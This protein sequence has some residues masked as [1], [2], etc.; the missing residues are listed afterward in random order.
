MKI[1]TIVGIRK[2]GKTTTVTRLVQELKRR[3]YQVGTVKTVFCP[4]FSMDQEG[5]N[6]DRHKKAGADV[7]GVKGKN[8]MN[9]IYPRGMDDNQFFP[10]LDADILLVE[11]DYEAGVPRIVCAHRRQDAL[12]RI[13]EYT[14]A[15]CGK[16]GGKGETFGSLPVIDILKEDKKAAD[17]VEKLP[18]VVFPIPL[19]ET[20][21][22]VSSF[23]QCG[24]RRGEKKCS[25]SLPVRP[26]SGSRKHI[27]LT[28]KKQVGKSTILE[29]A[30]KEL[31]L[32]FCGYRTLPYEIG[33]VRKG[34]Y[35]HGL[36][37]MDAFQNDCP[38]S[39]RAGERYS[40]P[41]TETFETLGTAI[42][43]QA[44]K[45]EKIMLAD[46]VGKLERDAFRFQQMFFRCLNEKKQVLGVLQDTDTPFV[47]AI[48]ER[49]DVEIWTVTEENR[50]C[51]YGSLIK[52][53]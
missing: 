4:T 18:D 16:I 13:N 49:P 29:K 11:G 28:G 8:E 36:E 3:G 2:S 7:V 37:E 40:Y 45:S 39:V 12:E 43:E 48:K 1:C 32:A 17:I 10:L 27:F 9:I 35:L 46:E 15:V 34:F 20:P 6:T 44:L 5:S 53:L 26:S 14:V 31:G 33:Q 42:L 52:R 38:I 22:G 47:N 19:L 25:P 51:L 24:C 30:E 21:E 23:C 41:L 50:E